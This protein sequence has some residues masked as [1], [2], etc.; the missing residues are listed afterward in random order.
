MNN[1]AL[2]R[3]LNRIYKKYHSPRY[4]KMDPLLCVQRFNDPS[5]IE[6]VGLVASC[7][8]YGRVERIIHSISKLLEIADND[9]YAFICTTSLLDKKRKLA[10]FRHR[11]TSGND[12][13]LLF[14]SIKCTLDNHGS[15]HNLFNDCYMMSDRSMK[16]IMIN[17]S[18]RLREYG[19]K[20]ERKSSRTFEYLIP[21]PSS[22]SACKR[23]N[24]Y[25]R[26][27]IR[28]NDGIDF[29]IWKNI[30]PSILI[31]PLDVHIVKVAK[32]FSLCTRKSV[33]WK[34]AEQ[35]T[36]TLKGVDPDDPVKYDFSLCRYGMETL[37][38]G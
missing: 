11:F 21:S 2:K 22:G 30:T 29:G 20:N 14:E 36:D 17:F 27:M 37:R 34:M 26:W 6:V 31:I 12:V 10:Q 32:H 18:T 38:A 1:S 24:M 16:T 5:Q 23:L 3:N 28:R 33:D 13:A 19:R 35:I 4:V 8:A 9:L 15:L 25:F 7:L